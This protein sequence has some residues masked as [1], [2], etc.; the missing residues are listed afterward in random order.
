MSG[1]MMDYPLTLTH[2]LERSA[3]LYPRKEIASRVA[4]GSMHRY[5][6]ADFHRRVHRLAH[7]LQGLGVKQGDRIGTL[8]WNSYRH[9]ELYFAVPCAG[10]VLHTLNLRLATDQLSYIINHAED[11]VIFVDSSLLPILDSIRGELHSV[12]HIV[13]IDDTRLGPHDSRLPSLVRAGTPDSYDYESLLAA[14][15]DQPFPWPLLDENTAA[16]TCYTSGTTGN[17][18][19]VLYTH[20]CLFLHSY[21]ICMADTFAL[22][23]RDTIL[24]LVPMFHANGWGIPY[25]GV[26]TGSRLVFSGRQLQP[27]D[28]ASLIQN[29]RATF[30][31]GVPTL[32]MSLYSFLESN[33]HDISSLR[34][35]AAAGSALPQ[36][37]IELYYNRY[38]IQFMLAWGMTETTPIA[39]VTSLKSELE[40]LPDKARFD[41][42]ARHGFPLAGVD[43]RIIDEQ[44]RE[45]PWDGVTMGELQ[46][47]GPWIT[48][49]YYNDP[50]SDDAFMDGWFRTGDVATIDSE[51][52][53]QIMDRTKDLV[54]SGGE[55][56]SSVDLENALMA[57]PKVMEAAVVGVFHPKWQERPLACIAPLPQFKNQITKEELL[58]FLTPRVAKWWLPDDIVFIE[59]VPKTSVGK[60]NKRALREQF[61]DYV[62]PSLV[63]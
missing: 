52:Y 17:P 11:R 24:Q 1:L 23:E 8:C 27:A 46:I 29:E 6:Y 21:G 45:L 19:G 40:G 15:S 5:T 20:R 34:S 60:F 59:S 3:K 58:E 49:G 44:G 47:R 48:S 61:K 26:M 4:D 37:F 7:A 22:S 55:W 38:G 30:T 53:I 16:A 56:I 25:A 13:V 28:I 36:Q 12:R 42:L 39:T 10:A 18:K 9:L 2:I 50:R 32:W 31:A 51:G 63:E 41:L 35:I 62:L 54:K 43:I 14:A 33:P 57:H